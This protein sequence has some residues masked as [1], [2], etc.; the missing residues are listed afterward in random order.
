MQR[1]KT[2]VITAHAQLLTFRR[3]DTESW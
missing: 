3:C 2:E 1:K